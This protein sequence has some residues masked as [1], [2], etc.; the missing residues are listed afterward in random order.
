MDFPLGLHGRSACC[1]FGTFESALM[2][3]IGL[4]RFAW[5]VLTI[6]SFGDVKNSEKQVRQAQILIPFVL[7]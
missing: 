7:T 4:C 3:T 1:V 5:Q 2:R 6:P